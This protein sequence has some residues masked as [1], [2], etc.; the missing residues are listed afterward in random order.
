MDNFFNYITKPLNPEH[1]DRWFR[2]NNIIPEKLELYYDFSLS[3]YY[4]VSTTYL[5][6]DDSFNDTKVK[7]SDKDNED[8]FKWCWNKI[9]SNFLK[10][11]ITFNEEGEHFIYF[12]NL[13]EE[14]YYDKKSQIP[15]NSVE[16]FFNDIFNREKSYTQ[17]DLD[18]IYN[19]Y[20]SLDKNLTI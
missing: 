13:F 17:V 8:H 14:I 11:N 15:R 10:E 5:G 18:L 2:V 7:M 9:I 1:V 20:K 4:L 6:D 19:I 16:V 12:K 3:L